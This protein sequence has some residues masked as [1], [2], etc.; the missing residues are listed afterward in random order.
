MHAQSEP[1]IKTGLNGPNAE[2]AWISINTRSKLDLYPWVHIMDMDMSN[3]PTYGSMLNQ[4]MSRFDL[5]AYDILLIIDSYTLIDSVALRQIVETYRNPKVGAAG[6]LSNDADG[7]QLL[8]E[9]SYDPDDAQ[10]LRDFSRKWATQHGNETSMTDWLDHVAL[11]FRCSAITSSHLSFNAQLHDPVYVKEDMLRRIAQTGWQLQIATGAFVH[12]ESSDYRLAPAA[13]RDL[14]FHLHGE[15]PRSTPPLLVSACLI[16]KNEESNLPDCLKSLDGF[17]DEIVIY[18]TGSSDGTAEIAR[19]YGATV[20]NGYWN[21]DFSKARN[22]ALASCKGRWILWI[23]ADERLSYNDPAG[24]RQS[25][26]EMPSNIEGCLVHIDNLEG[27]GVTSAFTHPACRM[28]R[29]T[30][31]HWHGRLHE[32]ISLIDRDAKR[33]PFLV[34]FS[35]IRLLHTGYL[36]EAVRSRAKPERNLALAVEEM[37]DLEGRD[38]SYVKISL[39][40]S[41]AMAGDMEE[42]VKVSLEAAESATDPTTKRLGIQT[43]IQGLIG[44]GRLDEALEQV[45]VLR[46]CSANPVTANS[47]EATIRLQQGKPESALAL[48]ETI[49]SREVDDDMFEYRASQ[50]AGIKARALAAMGRHSEAADILLTSLSEAGTLDA[51]L[52]DLLDALERAGRS[53][54]EIVGALEKGKRLTAFMAQI[55][56]LDPEKADSVLQACYEH[57]KDYGMLS[58]VMAAAGLVAK[59]LPVLN[60]LEWSAR[61]RLL[62]LGESCPLLGKANDTSQPLAE[63]ALAAATAIY[64]FGDSSAYRALRSILKEALAAD[65]NGTEMNDP[66][67]LKTVLA[68]IEVLA[69]GATARALLD[70][71]IIIYCHNDAIATQECLTSIQQNTTPGSYEV[72]LV[73]D[74]STDATRELEMASNPYFRIHRN[75]SHLGTME[76]YRLVSQ[77]ANAPCILLVD[78]HSQALPGWAEPLEGML[79]AHSRA[80]RKALTLT[81]R[82]TEGYAPAENAVVLRRDALHLIDWGAVRSIEGIP[83]QLNAP[84]FHREGTKE[85]TEGTASS[86]GNENNAEDT[87]SPQAPLTSPVHVI[88]QLGVVSGLGQA[89]RLLVDTLAAA[90]IRSMCTSLDALHRESAYAYPQTSN[91]DGHAEEHDIDIIC[92]YPDAFVSLL[93]NEELTLCNAGYRIGRWDWELETPPA[94]TQ[95]ALPYVDEI[96]VLSDFERASFS[97]ATSKPIHVFPY[98][99]AARDHPPVYS[100]SALGIPEGFLFLSM[101]DLWS[102][103]GRK[104]PAGL[105]EAFSRAFTPGEGPVL[106]IK[107]HNADKTADLIGLRHLARG[108]S[109]IVLVVNDI[110]ADDRIDSLV[111]NCDCYVS[112][113]RSEGFGLPLANAMSWG[114]PVIAT[115]YSGNLDF[116]DSSNSYLVPWRYTEPGHDAGHYL[117]SAIWAEPDLDAAAGIMRYVYEHQEEARARGALARES[118]RASHSPETSIAFLRERIGTIQQELLSP[119]RLPSRSI[120]DDATPHSPGNTGTGSPGRPIAAGTSPSS[121]SSSSLPLPPSRSISRLSR[122][123][124]VDLLPPGGNY[125]GS[126]IVFQ[127]VDRAIDGSPFPRRLLAKNDV[128][129]HDVAL[130]FMNPDAI[131][132]FAVERGQDFFERYTICCFDWPLE[133]L[134]ANM[135]RG[136]RYVNEIWVPSERAYR[137]VSSA[138]NK[139]VVKLPIQPADVMRHT[140]TTLFDRPATTPHT[141]ASTAPAIY[142]TVPASDISSDSSLQALNIDPDRP[143]LLSV[144]DTHHPFEMTNALG[145]IQAFSRA[146]PDPSRSSLRPM[147]VIIQTSG[148]FRPGQLDV[149]KK[150]IAGRDDMVIAGPLS[151]EHIVSL[152]G[153]CSGYISLHR[154]TGFNWPLLLATSFGIPTIATDSPAGERWSTAVSFHP[155]SANEGTVPSGC[156]PYPEGMSWTEPDIAEASSLIARVF[157]D[158]ITNLDLSNGKQILT[159]HDPPKDIPP[160]ASGAHATDQTVEKDMKSIIT[161]RLHFAHNAFRRANQLARLRGRRQLPSYAPVTTH[162]TDDMDGVD[163]VD[164]MDGSTSPGAYGRWLKQF[165]T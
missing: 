99:I 124:G 113:H 129:Q 96:W 89:A 144:I 61:L 118:I 80:G 140:F 133:E 93:D 31:C 88:G 116:M 146:Y 60:A 102:T 104:N 34:P 8:S 67:E 66:A 5:L 71:S 63:R 69:P 13:D 44:L 47:L 11:T 39:A 127:A 103:A 56:Q 62:R 35:K 75:P 159:R 64:A 101:L 49:G 164:D 43:A 22:A 59:R 14:F 145:T 142:D 120:E 20:I 41:K 95:R 150:A 19:G 82:L 38:E 94:L 157:E 83:P 151:M 51:H 152:T 58:Q 30:R 73:D 156:W 68:G 141:A 23:D 148:T 143:Y 46:G 42:A 77:L 16:T 4:A 112:L 74:A 149:I 110:Y 136:L 117:K 91:Y 114:K 134:S 2:D 65:R 27:T 165:D 153:R 162:D 17:A 36:D 7:K 55:V 9:T 21:D 29:R 52:G 50:F 32:Q 70:A 26:A 139:P 18:D 108:R 147:L 53:P 106:L 161:S 48:L 98:P 45:E 85:S 160:L 24:I 15:Y 128:A 154:A 138:V 121:T 111:A 3:P 40:R 105:I 84:L 126:L 158:E 28:F 79:D 10:S 86:E 100:R 115:G 12:H 6:P 57:W 130:L 123:D 131:P 81:G 1:A 119:A 54:G 37:E 135:K 78:Q 122:V 25:L 76:S 163:S 90:G 125:R 132:S 97:R 72:I 87:S 137:A 109:D 155:V 33:A 92:F 107:I